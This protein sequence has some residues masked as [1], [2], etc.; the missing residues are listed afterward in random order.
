MTPLYENRHIFGRNAG[1]IAVTVVAMLWGVWEFW[2]AA[3]GG[4]QSTGSMFGV[5]FLAG[6]AYSLYQLLTEQRDIVAR[7]ERDETSGALTVTVWRWQGPLRLIG[8]VTAWRPHV[9]VSGRQ[10]VLFLY[11]DAAGYPRPLRFEL[12]HN[13]DLTGLRSVAPGA[14]AEFEA[15]ATGKPAA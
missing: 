8:P 11:V 6:G 10:K 5:L 7:L 4:D 2:H 12:R 1:L 13:T 9:K 3:H 15:L 14:V